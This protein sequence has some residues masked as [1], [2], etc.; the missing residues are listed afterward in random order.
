MKPQHWFG[1]IAVGLKN[2]CGNSLR[3]RAVPTRVSE[4]W[5]GELERGRIVGNENTRVKIVVIGAG[6]AGLSAAHTL[7]RKSLEPGTDFIV[8]D[9]NEGPGGA[10]RHRWPSLTLG[11]AHGIHDLPGLELGKPDPEEPASAVVSRYYGSYEDEFALAVQRPYRV[12]GVRSTR[13]ND[14]SAPLEIT[15]RRA[16]GAERTWTAQAIINATG[17]WDQPFWPY[18]PGIESFA[19][20]QLHTKDYCSPQEFE[21]QRVLVVGGG[22]S[23]VQFLLPLAEAG[24]DT[25]WSTRRA[26]V[27]L[28]REFDMNWGID[29]ERRVRERTEAG[30]QTLSVVGATGLALTDEYKRGID[31]GTLISRGPLRSITTDG[32]VFAGVDAEAAGDIMPAWPGGHEHVDVILWATGFKPA[33]KHLAPLKLRSPHGGIATDGARVFV[34]PRVY[35]AGYGAGA[36]TIGA[37]RTGRLAGTAAAQFIAD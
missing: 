35:L 7:V 34:D 26:P 27:F 16:D 22:A 19:G 10:W 24:I 13:E 18:Y 23:A 1:E 33:L 9:A 2:R 11:K 6:Q 5:T 14:L 12:T 8:L 20:R 21:G 37:T 30:L 3:K 36:S 15:A 28:D 4:N 25:L 31:Q 17:A 29:V 32:V